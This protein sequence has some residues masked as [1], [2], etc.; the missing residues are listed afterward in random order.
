MQSYR[1][2]LVEQLATGISIEGEFDA[3]EAL[4]WWKKMKFDYGWG[5][6]LQVLVGEITRHEK[7]LRENGNLQD[8][9][10]GAWSAALMGN[11][12]AMME[13]TTNVQA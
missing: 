11:F 7:M 10:D 1:E 13:E 6:S 9:A 8:M 3:H 5:S 4:R 2:N 12:A